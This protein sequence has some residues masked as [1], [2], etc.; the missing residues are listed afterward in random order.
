MLQNTCRNQ[1]LNFGLYKILLDDTLCF[2]IPQGQ[3]YSQANFMFP[4][5]YAEAARGLWVTRAN[6]PKYPPFEIRLIWNENRITTL[7][8]S[9]EH[10][11]S[12]NPHSQP[13]KQTNF[14]KLYSD[15][16]VFWD[17]TLYCYYVSNELNL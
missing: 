16:K 3:E 4:T 7:L 1:W 11:S 14:T 2:E 17:T 8:P 10:F 5:A 6:S 9:L 12:Y 13:P 15:I